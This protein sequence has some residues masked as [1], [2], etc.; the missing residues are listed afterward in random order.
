MTLCSSLPQGL[1]AF[2]ELLRM[3]DGWIVQVHV[4]E[5]PWK[6]VED[7]P[8]IE[9]KKEYELYI[10]ARKEINMKVIALTSLVFLRCVTGVFTSTS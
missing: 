4:L 10:L 1:Q 8:I 2:H 5:V 7:V 9:G 3:H 6:Q